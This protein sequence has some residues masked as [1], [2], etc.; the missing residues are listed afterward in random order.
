[1]T[2]YLLDTC[3]AIWL[4]NGDAWREPAASELPAALESGARYY[5]SPITAWEVSMLV[6]KR[7]IALA[8]NPDLWFARLCDLPGVKLAAMPPSVLVA[9]TSLPGEAPDDPA[10]C[11]LLATARAFGY[12]LVTRDQR[13]L[14]Y[15]ALGHVQITAC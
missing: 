14:D 2:D 9:S 4:A 15:G 11:I 6:A 7:R 8:M 10:D 1:M 12:N 13:I 3:A 5:V